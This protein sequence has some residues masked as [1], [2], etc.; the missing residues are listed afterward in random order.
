[1]SKDK[2]A[3][4][5]IEKLKPYNHITAQRLNWAVVHIIRRNPTKLLNRII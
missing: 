5:K 2:K 3:N 1:M 4:K